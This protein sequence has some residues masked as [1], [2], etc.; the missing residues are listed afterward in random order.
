MHRSRA[1]ALATII[2]ALLLTGCGGDPAPATATAPTGAAS[3]TAAAV[4]GQSEVDAAALDLDDPSLAGFHAFTFPEDPDDEPETD[5]CAEGW[6]HR[7]D[8]NGDTASID[9]GQTT[10]AQT[11]NVGPFV[12]QQQTIQPGTGASD[13]VEAARTA[14]LGDCAKW[15]NQDGFEFSARE[16][17][18][19]GSVGD[20]SFGYHVSI[21]DGTTDLEVMGM[22][23][24]QGN[25][26]SHVE[27]AGSPS[28]DATKARAVLIAAGRLL[29][30]S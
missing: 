22:Y 23:M 14:Y 11:D 29:P 4:Y 10:F 28:I 20:E 17:K 19:V 6:G 1:L 30:K 7:F 25:L 8:A 21:S 9:S 3:P 15:T 2:G 18:D 5:P 16:Q 12:F 26:L 27:Y 24:S 13:I